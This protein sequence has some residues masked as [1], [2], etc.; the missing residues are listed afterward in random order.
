M[1]SISAADSVSFAIQRTRDF[2]FRPFTWGTYL[3]LGLVGILTEGLASNFSSSS[4]NSQSS[5]H[6][7]VLN[8]PFDIPALWIAAGVAIGLLVL[9]LCMLILYLVTRLRFAFF[10]CLI[11]NTK[12]IRPGWW[13]YRD[14]ATRFF[15]LN[16]IV[17]ACYALL[18]V[19][20]A[21][22]LAAGFFKLVH[23]TPQG[24]HPEW[25]SLLSLVFPLIPVI[26]VMIVIGVLAGIILRDW[27]LPHYALDD[28]S[29]GEAWSR[30]WTH[31]MAE[32][33]QF[34]V[35]IVLR[36]LLPTIA[37]VGL[38]LVL[39]I[40]G[41]TLAGSLAIVEWGIRSV[42]A[43]STGSSAVVGVLL[44][45]FFGVLGFGF[46]L[47]G[48]ICLGGPVSTASREY[49]LVFYGGRYKAL[50]DLLYPATP[51]V[52]PVPQRSA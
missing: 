38:F 29:A 35:Y 11:N 20:V 14:R 41:L 45:A 48:G 10:H 46:A 40:P 42:F 31:I 2:L 22:P 8:P 9:V 37:M 18:L 39:A 15:W 17:G 51:Q 5:G 24:G 4:H 49:A 16:V 44:Q 1:R 27:I 3:K 47:L 19:L 13:I 36:L 43:D 6:G 52:A 21:I 34:F 25:G 26:L 50:G 7:P 28:A 32:K 30:V 33:L 23:D 12:E